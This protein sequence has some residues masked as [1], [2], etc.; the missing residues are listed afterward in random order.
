VSG[1]PRETVRAEREARRWSFRAAATRG[2]IGGQAWQHYEDGSREPSSATTDGIGRAFGWPADWASRLEA[3]ERPAD[4]A[5]AGQTDVERLSDAVSW[6]RSEVLRLVQATEE[7]ERLIADLRGDVTAL[8]TGQTAA[9]TSSG[10][11]AAGPAR[12]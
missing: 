1:N 3:G 4:L 8:Q 11:T 5:T 9:T 12:R 6:L 10:S 7:Q 2:G